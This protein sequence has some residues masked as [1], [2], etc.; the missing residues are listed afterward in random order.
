MWDALPYRVGRLRDRA[1]RWLNA[2]AVYELTIERL[3]AHD[4]ISEVRSS[5]LA[6]VGLLAAT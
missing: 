2:E 3:H 4:P 5:L 6:I 1:K